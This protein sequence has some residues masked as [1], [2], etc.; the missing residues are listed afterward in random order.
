[1]TFIRLSL[2]RLRVLLAKEFRQVLRDPRMRFFVI[3]P[4]LVQLVIFGYAATFDVSVAEV[5]VVDKAHISASR[6]LIDAVHATGH[7]NLHPAVDMK[8]AA[9][10]LE[11]SK[12]RAIMHFPWDFDGSGKLQLIA[13]GS[14]SNSAQLVVG[15]LSAT[16]R[17][18]LLQNSQPPV[19]LVTRAWFNPNLDDQYYFI[20]GI[21][22]NVVLIATMIL[23]AMTVV[24][25]RELGT[26]E[27]LMVTPLA[28]LEFIIG[29]LVPV[30]FIGLLD[31]ALVTI[32]TVGWFGVPFRGDPLA[33]LLGSML[34]LMSTL[35]MGLLI[36]SFA[37]TQQQA[38]LTAFFFLIPMVILSGFAFP[39]R[40]MPEWI[41]YITYLD[42]LRYYLEV[43]RDLFL[44]GGG[45][46][47]HPFQFGM[48][49]LLGSCALGLSLIRLR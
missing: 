42:P 22:A 5:A 1:M 8:T 36:S 6:E 35:G 3:V 31:A 23:V 10:L 19:E 17:D 15:Q 41:Q 48:M 14:D 26:L 44:K 9:G 7:F 39:I 25:E 12:V 13:D 21:M 4:P 29:K 46:T 27:R 20:P 37:S 16:L 43:I 18:H 40:N 32:I 30:A 49:A 34:F 28:R 2:I 47:S 38:M 45:I 11:R 33:L 24:R